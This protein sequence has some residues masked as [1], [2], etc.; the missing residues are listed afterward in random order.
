M[1]MSRE[2]KIKAAQEKFKRAAQREKN[3][4]KELKKQ[5][6]EAA[7]EERAARTKRLI[8]VGAIMESAIHVEFDTQEKLD[9]LKEQAAKQESW[10][11]ANHSFLFVPPK[12]EEPMTEKPTADE[13]KQPAADE[14]QE[15]P[16]VEKPV[17]PSPS[18]KPVESKSAEKITVR[19]NEDWTNATCIIAP[20]G[21]K[22]SKG[23][24]EHLRAKKSAPFD[25]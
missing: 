14:K 16:P 6:S 1:A 13:E 7:K 4:K 20:D 8:E 21:T 18:V 19:W 5:L 23:L 25:Y 11:R 15:T 12:K 9:W 2:E 10:L 22:Y 3:A 24:A 17:T